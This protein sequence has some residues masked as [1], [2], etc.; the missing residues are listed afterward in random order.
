VRTLPGPPRRPLVGSLL[1]FR[2]DRLGLFT[3]LARTHGDAVRFFLGPQEVV[4]LSHPAHVHDVLVAGAGDFAKG[5]ILRRAKVLLGEGLLTAEGDHH[6]RQRRLVQP[7]FTAR[8]VAGYTP[9]MAAAAERVAAGWTDGTPVDAHAAMLQIT[10]DAAG[11]ALFSADV[12]DRAAGVGAAVDDVLAAYNLLFL[13]L[14]GVLQRLPLPAVRRLR[15][16][17][18]WLE[19]FVDRLVNERRA[20][21]AQHGDVLG[22]LLDAGMDDRQVRDEVLTLLLAGHETTASALTWA[23]H[24][25]GADPAASERLRA[26]VD[27][28]AADGPLGAEHVDRLPFARGVLAESL[29]LFPPSWAMGREATTDHAL[30]GQGTVRAGTAVVLSQWVVHRDERWWPDAGTFDPGRWLQPDP[31]RP[32]EAYFPF[33]AGSRRCIGEA[34]AW[35]EGILV[36]AAIA[37]RWRLEPTPGHTARPEP[38][39]T[40]R[41]RDVWV[42]P[43]RR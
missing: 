35:A 29:R 7:A 33:G 37:R 26:E 12:S 38:L 28:A 31:G 27:A 30:A 9:A 16:G 41:P 42:T 8:R 4:L 19:G 23:L 15:R 32:R 11:A 43:Q 21:R 34:F 3:D 14:S 24:L 1:E 39:L 20:S 2:R 40:L 10:V 5:P 17:G 25:L 22:L 18:R 6:R 13:P 36:L